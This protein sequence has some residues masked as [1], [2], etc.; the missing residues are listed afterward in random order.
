MIDY[1]PLVTYK[2][3]RRPKKVFRLGEEAFRKEANEII[4]DFAWR[5]DQ[6]PAEFSSEDIK[7]RH[8]AC[9]YDFFNKCRMYLDAG[10]DNNQ[11]PGI[12]EAAFRTIIEAITET[13]AKVRE[14]TAQGQFSTTEGAEGG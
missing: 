5:F 11:A 3:K 1:T 14:Q 10:F 12:A 13:V 8:D 4:K 7:R 2:K 9:L 6:E